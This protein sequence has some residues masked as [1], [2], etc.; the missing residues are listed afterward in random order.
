M[1]TRDNLRTHAAL[2]AARKES[3]KRQAM[4]CANWICGEFSNT[5]QTPTEF[6]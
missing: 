6:A 3:T 2:M 1:L 5:Q 4:L